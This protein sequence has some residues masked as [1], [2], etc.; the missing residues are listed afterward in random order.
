[1]AVTCTCPDKHPIHTFEGGCAR[2]AG[3]GGECFSCARGHHEPCA[4]TAATFGAAQAITA[5]PDCG[6]SVA[7]HHGF[8]G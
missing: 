3:P 6:W 4:R 8:V 7:M 2:F 1:V 5:C